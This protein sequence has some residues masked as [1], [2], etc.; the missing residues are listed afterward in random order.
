MDA[1]VKTSFPTKVILIA[2]VITASAMLSVGLISYNNHL[3]YIKNDERHADLQASLVNVLLYDEQLTEYVLLAAYSGDSQWAERYAKVESALASTINSMLAVAAS[4][5][6]NSAIQLT[7]KANQVLVGM[8][9]QAFKAIEDGEHARALNLLN[10][11]LYKTEKNLYKSGLRSVQIRIDEQRLQEHSSQES[12]LRKVEFLVALTILVSTILWFIVY[13]VISKWRLQLDLEIGK[14]TDAEVRVLA[15]NNELESRIEKRTN[16]LRKSQE[17]LKHQVN[18]DVLTNLPNRR[19]VLNYL[20]KVLSDADDK[21]ICVM[22][23]DLDNFKQVNDTLGHAVGDE[24]LQQAAERLKRDIGS[25]DVV[26]RLGGDEFLIVSIIA[27]G[28]TDNKKKLE[29]TNRILHRFKSPFTLG[30]RLYNLPISPSIGIAVSPDDGSTVEELMRNADTAMY[31]AKDGGRNNACLFIPEMTRQ[32]NERLFLETQLRAAISSNNQFQLY[33]QPQVDL[34]SNQIVGAEALLRWNHPEDGLILPDKFIPVAEDTGL[35]V[36][37]GQWVLDEAA[38]QSREWRD[39]HSIELNVSINVSC[40]Q[41]ILSNFFDTV[42]RTLKAHG[43]DSRDFGI[44]ITE[45]SLIGNDPVSQKNINALSEMGVIL[46]LDD[47]G[48]GYSALSY[49]QQYP[50]DYLKID[51]C[52]IRTILE[53]SNDASLVEGIINM[54]K[55]IGLKVVAE[56]TETFEQCELLRQ[57]GCDIAQGYYYSKPVLSTELVLFVQSWK[58]NEP[59]PSL[60]KAS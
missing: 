12:T 4:G 60:L 53:V 37:I 45:S 44:E 48:T 6:I 35:I 43:V 54:S 20:R 8:E 14:R 50:F 18:T 39:N 19:F 28:D 3:N 23:I 25:G 13:R 51:R 7:N 10:S 34:V 55:S 32:N 27:D 33:Y 57:Y 29:I 22:L 46:S 9:S 42:Q 21:Q 36:E 31:A 41:L 52:F 11:D 15:L 17:R 56:G 40:Q 49:L 30:G 16:Q 58:G 24:L 5:E 59:G 38:R 47:F 2:T 26:A 1:R